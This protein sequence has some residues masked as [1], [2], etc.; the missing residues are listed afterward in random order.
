MSK[1][2]PHELGPPLRLAPTHKA[3]KSFEDA[4]LE[5]LGQ[6]ETCTYH[7]VDQKGQQMPLSDQHPVC[8]LKIG[9]RVMS[10]RN[11]IDGA[12]RTGTMALANGTQGKV[13]RFESHPLAWWT[14]AP[15]ST[16]LPVVCWYPLN[17]QP[18]ESVVSFLAMFPEQSE[19]EHH[20]ESFFSIPLAL[21]EALTIHKALGMTIPAG[22]VECA[23]MFAY[24]QF[25][26]A[27]T[28]HP[29]FDHIRTINFQP[30][31]VIPPV[32]SLREMDRLS[33]IAKMNPFDL[34]GL[35]GVIVGH[36]WP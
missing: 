18:F 34:A 5:R 24:A 4:Q 20:S 11:V 7:V 14:K 26:E 35:L 19:Q 12:V 6:V 13:A 16:R 28:R 9:C 32:A 17:C 15:G 23:G 10:T 8:V 21:A 25:F 29:S 1:P 30:K 33:Q 3:Y 2:L 27:L 36:S 31:H 22:E